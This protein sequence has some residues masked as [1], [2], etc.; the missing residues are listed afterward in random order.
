MNTAIQQDE[1]GKRLL[2][3]RRMNQLKVRYAEAVRG[4]RYVDAE[5]IRRSMVQREE[6]IVREANMRMDGERVQMYTLM[7]D[8]TQADRDE[9][10][11][12]TNCVI[13]CCDMI[14]TFTMD[15]NQILHRSHPDCHIEMFDRLIAVGKEAKAQMR[16]MEDATDTLYQT[17]FTG[18]ADKLTEMV[19]NKACSLIRRVRSKEKKEV[20]K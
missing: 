9:L 1:F 20:M 10:N 17:E 13:L 5:K 12:L 8:M 2:N 18:H 3:D 7:G 4:M 11:T 14:E 15:A 6:E 19:R 16:F